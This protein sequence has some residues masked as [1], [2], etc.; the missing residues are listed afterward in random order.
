LNAQRLQPRSNL[1]ANL[2]SGQL[3]G[4]QEK[5]IVKAEIEVLPI[6][7]NHPDDSTKIIKL[8]ASDI[9]VKFS[10]FNEVIDHCNWDNL[11]VNES[12]DGL[13]YNFILEFDDECPQ[14]FLDKIRGLNDNRWI[15]ISPNL[16]D[17]PDF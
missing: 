9:G 2:W 13:L 5:G 1:R 14:D 3:R 7:N 11:G 8:L 4:W 17:E 15:E 10:E 6:S 12:N 16:F